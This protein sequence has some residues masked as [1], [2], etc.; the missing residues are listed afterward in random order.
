MRLFVPGF[1]ERRPKRIAQHYLR[2]WFIVD[3]LSCLPVGYIQY[4][5][6]SQ[7]NE[8][9]LRGMKA[10]RLVRKRI[11]IFCAILYSK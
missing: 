4:F 5:L 9:E 6:S 7:S 3:F 2:R 10:L 1:L 8:N 11:A